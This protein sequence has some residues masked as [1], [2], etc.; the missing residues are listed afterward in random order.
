[1][2]EILTR[3]FYL[4]ASECNSQRR[5]S[6]PLLVQR[7]IETATDHASQLGVGPADLREHNLA[8]V[9]SRL[10]LDMDA[11]PSI[12]TRYSIETW[13]ESINRHFT[14]RCFRI[15]DGD[16][17][18]SGYARTVWIAIDLETRR[19]GDMTD[20]MSHAPLVNDR[21]PI[22]RGGKIHPVTVPEAVRSHRFSYC[23]IDFNRHVNSCRYIEAMLNDRSVEFYD[24]HPIRRF[25]IAYMDE[26]HYNDKVEISRSTTAG[27]TTYQITRDG[28]PA[29]RAVIE[30]AGI[31]TII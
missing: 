28:I 16:G 7:L 5:I 22:K 25:E 9:L 21:C 13:V 11:F 6:L 29:T 10:S 30:Y 2:N 31:D 24:E 4:N 27:T 1:M 26:I 3:Q 23:D 19:G 17:N 20:I 12:D 15:T 18:T 14:E 8:W